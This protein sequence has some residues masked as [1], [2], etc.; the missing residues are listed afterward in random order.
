MKPSTS[1]NSPPVKVGDIISLRA[2]KMAAGGDFVGHI[3]KF[4]VFIT[5][6]APDEVGK[7]E[8]TEVARNFA[9]GRLVEIEQPSPERVAPPCPH[10]AECGGCDLQ[11]LNYPA[12]LAQKEQMV[13]ATLRHLGQV[14]EITLPPIIGMED[15][16]AYRNK[17]E[18]FAGSAETGARFFGFLAK[19]SHQPI[20]ISHCRV[21][22]PLNEQI[23]L[24]AIELL[25]QIGASEAEKAALVKIIVRASFAFNKAQ[26]TLV[27]L[28]KS[29]FLKTFA[30]ALMQK[31][32]QI[33]GVSFCLTRNEFSAHHS[34]AETL[35]GSPYL[36]ET[37][38]EYSFRLSPDSFFQVNPRQA[39]TLTE[40]VLANAW[41]KNGAIVI[42][43]YS[44]V[45]TFLL[46]LAERARHIIGIEDAA[47]ALADARANIGKPSHS[48]IRLYQ[49]KVER[50]L[51]RLAAKE[52]RANVIVLDPPRKG[53]GRMV[54][55]A[56]ARFK[57]RAIVLVSCDPATLARDLGFLA[58]LDYQ[59]KQVQIIDMFPHTWH[60]ECVAL[61]VPAG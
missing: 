16:W 49:G 30:E 15:P 47:S 50:I 51:P 1:E 38:G 23:R 43:G 6:S 56:A 17:A 3:E 22:H 26:V 24:A 19:D 10:F 37:L 34:P 5:G 20:P 29:E 12:Q 60:T 57:P 18:Y 33:R 48:N 53:G 52:R 2:E 27:T 35:A 39:T 11:H 9:R 44:G 8:I 61:C 25:N 45:G 13:K 46:P 41:V 54:M 14:E 40:T 36:F 7:V 58:A 4:A 55:A 59:A 31:I 32:H 21:Q 28:A 42:E